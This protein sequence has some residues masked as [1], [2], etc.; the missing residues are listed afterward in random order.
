MSKDEFFLVGQKAFISNEEGEL[1]ILV[2]PDRGLDLPGGKIQEGEED[3]DEALRREVREETGLE[4][5][6]G[7][8]FVRWFRKGSPDS[9]F[10]GKPFF[11][12]G[13]FCKADSGDII[14]SDEHTAYHWVTNNNYQEYA[15]EP[16]YIDA[17]KTFFE[18][19]SDA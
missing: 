9:E 11:I 12:I 17:V 4:I 3:F 5:K 13:F 16:E 8:P 1:L 18:K 6:I 2:D 14:L 19:Y 15:G 7:K 10:A